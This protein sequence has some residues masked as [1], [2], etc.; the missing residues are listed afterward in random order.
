MKIDLKDYQKTNQPFEEYLKWVHA[1][2]YIG[3]DDDM[4]DNFNDWLGTLDGEDYIT[5]GNAF[6]KFLLSLP[7]Y[8]E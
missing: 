4:L 8:Q 3:T 7:L 6:S 2:Q 5:H 1:D